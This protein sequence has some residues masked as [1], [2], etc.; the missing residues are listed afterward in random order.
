MCSLQSNRFLLRC[1]QLQLKGIHTGRG[2]DL[3]QF[4]LV[5][6][7]VQLLLEHG[8]AL[9]QLTGSTVPLAELILQLRAFF[10]QFFYGVPLLSEL[11]FEFGAAC[12]RLLYPLLSHR[13]NTVT[14]TV[15]VITDCGCGTGLNQFLLQSFS[16][17]E[18][19]GMLMPRFIQLYLQFHSILFRGGEFLL[20]AGD[21]GQKLGRLIIFQKVLDNLLGIQSCLMENLI[22][23]VA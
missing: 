5:L 7:F 21:L 18:G 20:N 19:F 16:F 12:Q 6:S 10:A 22:I 23:S 15:T 9:A 3:L 17:L 4:E 11:C 2:R 1:V 14:V 8:I 13:I